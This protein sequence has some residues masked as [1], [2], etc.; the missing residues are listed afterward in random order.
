MTTRRRPRAG[1]AS[2]LSIVAAGVLMVFPAGAQQILPLRVDCGDNNGFPAGQPGWL[3]LSQAAAPPGVSCTPA[4]LDTVHIAGNL[5]YFGVTNPSDVMTIDPDELWQTHRLTALS[6]QDSSVI[7]VTGL[8]A[9]ALYRVKLELGAG[10]PWYDL[11][12]FTPTA[13]ATVSRRVLVETPKPGSTTQWRVAAREV[14]CTA[15]YGGNTLASFLGATVPLWIIA[16]ADGAGVLKV[17]LST[18]GSDPLFLT[19]FEVHA[20]EPLPVIYRRTAAGPLQSSVPA[21]GAFVAAFNAG[22][23]AAA[24][25]FALALAD[26]WQRGVA[27]ATLIGWLD[28]SREGMD[29]L[30]PQA[31][32]ALAAANGHPGAAWLSDQLAT[33]ARALAHLAAR[34]YADAKLCPSQGG[35]G[36]LNT[37]CAGQTIASF[38]Q[39][40]TNVNA[41]VALRLLSGLVAPVNGTTVLDDMVSWNAGT[42]GGSAFEPSPLVFA[43]LKR[44]GVTIAAINPMLG[45]NAADPES[46][47][48]RQRLTDIFTAFVSKGFA[49]TDFPQDLELLLFE[50]YATHPA[51][52]PKNWP[53]ADIAALFT[54]AQIASSWW[55]AEVAAPATDPSVP[56]WARL[57]RE[58]EACL[59]AVADY[60]LTVRWRGGELGGGWG[61]DVEIL[62]QLM[63]VLAARQAQQDRRLVDR[64][65]GSVRYGLDDFALV[66]D[67]YYSGALTDVEHSAELTTNPWII[68]R[69]LFGHSATAGELALDVTRHLKNAAAPAG[70]FAAPTTA[71]RLHF[72]NS[73]FNASAVSTDAST[74][75]DIPL[76]GRA[77]LPGIMTGF[78]APLAPSHPLLADLR[79]WAEGWRDDALDTSSLAS[80]KPAGFLAPAQWPANTLGSPGAWW[81]TTSSPADKSVFATSEHS[82]ILELLRQAW[83]TSAAPDRWRFL[84]PGVRMFRAVMAWEDAG[85]PVSPAVGSTLWAGQQF[86]LGTRFGSI[87]FAW[88]DDLASDAT[89]LTTPDPFYG[90]ATT[91]VDAA[92]LARL[93]TWTAVE[94]NNQG[95]GL[96]YALGALEPCGPHSGKPTSVLEL[97]YSATRDY[98]RACFPLLTSCCLHTDRAFVNQGGGNIQ[99]LAGHTGAGL[100]EGLHYAPLVGWSSRLGPSPELAI[101]CN[102][103]D[104]AGTSWS[105]FVQNFGAPATLQLRLEEG[106][107]PGRYLVETGAATE[108]C[109]GF[110]AGTAIASAFVQKRGSGAALDVTL[111]S[112]LSLVRAT[113]LGPPDLAAQRHDLAVDPPAMEVVK[114]SGKPTLLRLRAHVVNAGADASP[115]STLRLHV[116]VF[117][118]DGSVLPLQ[119]LPPELL[120]SETAIPPLAGSTGFGFA[121]HDAELSV[122]FSGI[123][124]QIL[125]MGLGLQ[126]RAEVAG[127]PAESDLLNNDLSRG[128]TLAELPVVAQ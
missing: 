127:L 51:G 102:A 60:W 83:T 54:P 37:D 64:M 67:G 78:H 121:A 128:W 15:G 96:V 109:D 93:E 71:G 29:W 4:P 68:A 79:A 13:Y 5:P 12:G 39:A 74:A 3:Q 86:K 105:A 36:F 104:V 28:G 44:S 55:G 14:R 33:Y 98:I 45:V 82:Y 56:A 66:D 50:A 80:G 31:L 107:V 2:L 87:A 110:P 6:L 76:D 95:N 94:F 8:Q 27:L 17:R 57:Q 119:D 114:A 120:V 108:S 89:L 125:S 97:P 21:L 23:F 101:Q 124:V 18:S 34:G 112:G 32:V 26:P 20:H 48:F 16:Q 42:L 49:A 75:W 92:L 84:L 47:E 22:D 46:L 1:S 85:K 113:R 53:A 115:G 25:S 90:N 116:A 43:A 52:H 58:A 100:V 118:P 41:H 73:V 10:S 111:G 40:A 122:P 30:V 35:T 70:G 11:V 123:V 99:R 19:G 126:L 117:A 69:G 65:D 7:A 72:R 63:P 81:N 61:D 106:L 88:R 24:Q 59:R 91:Y 103:R 62:V 9:S 77:M 38:G